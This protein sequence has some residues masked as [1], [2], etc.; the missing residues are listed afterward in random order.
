MG[1][2]CAFRGCRDSYQVPVALS[3]WG[4]LDSFITDCFVSNDIYSGATWLPEIAKASLRRRSC[5]ALPSLQ[6]QQLKRRFLLEVLARAA[7]TAEDKFYARYDPA[8]GA[9]MADAA[10]SLG[11]DLFAYSPYAPEA[12]QRQYEHQPTK[13]LFQ[14]HPH[15]LSEKQILDSDSNLCRHLGITLSGKLESVDNIVTQRRK[16]CDGAWAQADNVICASS[17]T[18]KTLISAG[19]PDSKISVVPYGVVIDKSGLKK[20]WRTKQFTALFVGSGIQR[21]GLH[22]LIAAWKNANLPERSRLTIVSR[23]LDDGIATLIGDDRTVEVLRG[24]SQDGLSQ[25]YRT[26]RL[27]IMPSL[28]EGFGQVYL[29]ALSHGLPVLGT[30]NTCLPDL[31][32]SSDGIFLSKT[33]NVSSLSRKLEEVADAVLMD[34]SIE[35]AA[36]Q[37]AMKYSWERFREGIRNSLR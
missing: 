18:R 30:E 35:Q 23:V 11:A 7:G 3:E 21:K 15:Y 17:F 16:L 5:S 37:C 24:V 2:V 14:F 8:Y 33:G 20:K 10:A 22:H 19:C 28:I 1:F 34:S 36:Y 26:S 25:L 9:A 4:K 12:F 29:E 31:G 27:F 6:V 32:D 13:V